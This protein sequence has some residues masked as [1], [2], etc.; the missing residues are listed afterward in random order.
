MEENAPN[1]DAAES[2]IRFVCDFCGKQIRVPS[3]H[4]GKKGKCPQCK[5][6]VV[7]PYSMS[8]P[9]PEQVPIAQNLDTDLFLKPLPPDERIAADVPKDKQYEMLRQSAGFDAPPP[10][11]QRKHSALVD[12]F[13]YPA[14]TQGLIFLAIAVVVP[15]LIRLASIVLCVFGA[16]FSLMNVAI[17]MYIYWFLAQCVR[18]SAAG[19]LRAPETMAETP[20]IWELLWE[21]CEL[22]ACLTLCAIPALAYYTYARKIDSLFWYL[23]GF[24]AFVYPMTLLSVIMFDSTSGL[25]PLVIIPSIFSVFFQYCGLV[26]LISAIIFLYI[27]TTRLFPDGFF[28]RLLVS[29]L[30]QAVELY[31]A[32]MAMH[33]LGRFYFKYQKKLN[34]DV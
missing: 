30:I 19:G 13:F 20:G 32:M 17:A 28:L 6:I 31:L 27:Q 26:V 22:V 10:L 14:N 1:Q 23:A 16:L 21:V 15:I 8:S 34:W 33:L 12:V 5:S 9:R 11:P 18:D 29:P 4:A 2:V 25:N 3:V 7:I 24:G